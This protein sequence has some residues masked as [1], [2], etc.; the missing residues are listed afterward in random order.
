MILIDKLL[1][2]RR[3]ILKYLK[4]SFL[5]ITLIILTGCA[6]TGNPFTSAP[7]AKEDK[8][9]VVFYRPKQHQGS[10]V[11]IQLQDNDKDI[12]L[13][14]N[15]QFIIYETEPGKHEFRTNTAAIDKAVTLEVEGG[16][17]YYFATSIRVGF[18]V[19]SWVLTRVFDDQAIEEL[20]VCCKDGK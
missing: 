4:L 2:I 14:Q 19:G 11:S 8:A 3:I 10:A 6:A 17:T 18:W 9:I 5:V 7:E 15:G 1:V 13:L 16:K 20:K 12:G